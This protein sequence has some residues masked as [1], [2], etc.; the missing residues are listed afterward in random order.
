[1]QKIVIVC[2]L[3]Y[4]EKVFITST[5]QRNR[6]FNALKPQKGSLLLSE[7][8]MLDPNFER[9]VI[10][11]CEHDEKDGT[12][13]FV[14]NH[15]SNLTLADILQGVENDAFPL[16]IGGPVQVDAL[17]FIHHC[18]DKIENSYQLI[19]DIYLGG[20]FEQVIF[21]VNENLIEP[22]DIKFFIGY[23]GWEPEQLEGEIQENSWAVHNRFPTDILLL[24][25]GEDLWKQALISMGPKYAH[26]ANFPKS[27][28]LN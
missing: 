18:P 27:P 28:D 1:M 4:I 6:M 19:D 11:L 25:D 14:L 8:F 3:F 17:Y 5:Q 12:M 9:S 13:G 21:L 20:D 7:P 10:L 23:A 16:Y 26:V 22:Q 2:N 15:K 24:G